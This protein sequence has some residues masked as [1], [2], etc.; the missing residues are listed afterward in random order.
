[1]ATTENLLNVGG[2]TFTESEL[3]ESLYGCVGA[4]V[5]YS[6]APAATK[7]SSAKFCLEAA[8]TLGLKN[9]KFKSLCEA[10]VRKAGK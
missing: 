9:W 7:V 10:V 4:L 6:S 2:K 3:L 5:K 8:K 1:M